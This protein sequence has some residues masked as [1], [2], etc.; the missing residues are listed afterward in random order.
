MDSSA[1][2]VLHAVSNAASEGRNLSARIAGSP[3]I[4]TICRVLR[5][6]LPVEH[7][8]SVAAAIRS[9]DPDVRHAV[10]RIADALVF[11]AADVV[12]RQPDVPASRAAGMAA[13]TD[14]GAGGIE[15]HQN[16]QRWH[17]CPCCNRRS[18]SGAAKDARELAG[19]QLG[20]GVS[21]DQ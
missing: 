3:T 10:A 15:Q 5:D 11:Q 2:I 9:V 8:D 12:V 16:V 4:A 7:L 6:G 14:P 21:V 17:T 19:F 13:A 20:A 18:R 1:T